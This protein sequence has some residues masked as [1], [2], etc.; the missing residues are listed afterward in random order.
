M[1]TPDLPPAPAPT[2]SPAPAPAKKSNTLVI[3]LCVIF[4]L[5][6]LLLASCVGTCMYVGK[7]AKDYAK[8]SQKSPQITALATIAAFT[9]DVEVVSKDLDAGTIVLKNKKT[10]EITKLSAK[11]F[12]ADRVASVIQKIKEG[13]PL[14]SSANTESMSSAPEPAA[15]TAPAEKATNSS[16][17]EE[18]TS[19]AQAAAQQSA[20]KSFPKDFPVYDGSAVKTLEASQNTFAGVA[21]NTHTFSTSDSPEEVAEFY[22]KKLTADGYT[23]MASENSS[24]GNGPKLTRI[25]QKDGAAS[26]VNI[27]VRVEDGK[28]HV[29]VNQVLL[30]QK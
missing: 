24:N 30:K 6:F 28:T 5:L 1:S 21:S 22:G 11:D 7:K 4:G 2:P 26:T 12:S 14:T 10:G 27:E 17:A 18:P 25:F 20:I 15:E 23:V 8:D 9:P 29:Q 3:V 13:K 19:S 16:S